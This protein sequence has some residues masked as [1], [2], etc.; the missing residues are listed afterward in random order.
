MRKFIRDEGGVVTTEFVAIMPFFLFF[1][2]FFVDTC[3]VYFTYS[4]MYATARDTARR[5]STEQLETMDEV[6]DYVAERLLPH[7][8][9]Y[10]LSADPMAGDIDVII[11]ANVFE[12]ALFGALLTRF[13]G[14]TMSARATVRR[15]PSW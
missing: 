6:R 15:E 14:E 3:M 13:V 11:T 2:A 8:L 7:S 5:M 1:F 12:S 4:D 10:H 9:R